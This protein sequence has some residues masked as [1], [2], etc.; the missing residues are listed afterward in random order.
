MEMYNMYTSISWAMA[1]GSILSTVKCIY[2]CMHVYD[3]NY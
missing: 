1:L 2:K 3:Y